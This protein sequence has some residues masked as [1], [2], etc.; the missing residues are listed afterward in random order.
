VRSKASHLLVQVH[1]LCLWHRERHDLAQHGVPPSVV[2]VGD[3]AVHIL[4]GVHGRARFLL[5]HLHSSL[6]A[7]LL[8][9]LQHQL[10]HI[11]RR[12][13]CRGHAPAK[14][15]EEWLLLLLLLV[16]VVVVV[17][18]LVLDPPFLESSVLTREYGV[19]SFWRAS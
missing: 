9:E 11:A 13:L 7:V 10:D 12:D 14:R 18:V 15:R 16:V 17:V 8:A 6:Q 1:Q 4:D 5:Q 19:L 2:D 3:E